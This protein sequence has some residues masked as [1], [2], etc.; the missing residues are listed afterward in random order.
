MAAPTTVPDLLERLRRSGLVPADRLDGF[1]DGLRASGHSP[2]N[3]T[4]LLAR[5]I[6]AGMITQFHA[7]KLAAGKYKGFQIGSYLILDQIGTGGMGQVYLAEHTAMRRLVAL[8]VFPP[9]SS[10]DEV[11]KERFLREARAAAA[12]DH[13]NIVRVFDLCQEGRLLYLVMEYVEGVSL[14]ALVVRHGALEVATACHYA[15]QIAFGLEHAHELGFV[16]RDI[17]PANLLLD[18]SGVIRILD[19]GLVRSEADA[20]S[21]LTQQL[22]SKSILGTADYLAPEQAVDSSNVDI[23]ADLYSLGAT[24]YFLLAGRPLFPEGRTAQKLVWQQ[25]KDPTPINVLRPDVPAE[26]AAVIHKLL[27]KKPE[28]RYATPLEIF[29]ALAEWDVDDVPP[30][31]ESVM[32]KTPARVQASRTAQPTTGPRIS[33]TTSQILAL[34]MRSGSETTN[35]SAIHRTV[36]GSSVIGLPAPRQAP[37]SSETDAL[38][39][40]ETRRTPSMPVRPDLS[41]DESPRR[42]FPWRVAFALGLGAG[43]AAA[44]IVVLTLLLFGRM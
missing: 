19:L 32:P 4:E 15:R 8:K 2:A 44:A 21:G 9:Y 34:A 17:K 5:M 26:L 35:M 11:A 43:F 25:I 13:P 16:H 37:S 31:D 1:L 6:D 24:L 18:R 22:D 42:G 33:G 14:Q 7:T 29:D 3:N 20:E 39:R 36:G 40:E 38:H 30:P 27:E 10:D 23:R 12:L 28:N 41:P